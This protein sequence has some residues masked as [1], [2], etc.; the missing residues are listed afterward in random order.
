M[1]GSQYRGTSW[2]SRN[3]QVNFE[4]HRAQVRL[5]SR[6]SAEPS[7]SLGKL[8]YG[9]PGFL[10]IQSASAALGVS[11]APGLNPLVGF[12]FTVQDLEASW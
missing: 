9:A 7:P 8:S 10:T 4:P 2:L 5:I 12:R 3:V 11:P 1:H 6:G